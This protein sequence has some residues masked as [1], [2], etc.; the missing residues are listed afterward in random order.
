MCV[1]ELFSKAP[2]MNLVLEL[3]IH[4]FGMALIT[5]WKRA[6]HVY[7]FVCIPPLIPINN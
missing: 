3:Q 5:F 7:I 1:K 4:F 6:L 2:S